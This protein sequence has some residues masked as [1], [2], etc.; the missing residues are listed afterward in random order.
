MKIKILIFILIFAQNIISQQPIEEIPLAGWK[1]IKLGAWNM[2]SGNNI[3]FS[4]KILGITSAQV[5]GARAVIRDDNG[6]KYMFE[7]NHILPTGG[8]YIE[9]KNNFIFIWRAKNGVF[10][11]SNF[12]KKTINRGYLLIAYIN[13]N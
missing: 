8:I 9:P 11:T 1:C 4:L 7:N 2:Q 10:H 6:T 13:V 12:S 3:G 5:V